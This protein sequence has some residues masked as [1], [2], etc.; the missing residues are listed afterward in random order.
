M[1]Q[2][3]LLELNNIYI[4]LDLSKDVIFEQTLLQLLKFCPEDPG[5]EIWTILWCLARVK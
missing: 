3:P 1:W 5:D 2:S 4:G